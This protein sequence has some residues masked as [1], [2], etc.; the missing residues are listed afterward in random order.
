MNDALYILKGLGRVGVMCISNSR[1]HFLDLDTRVVS[2]LRFNFIEFP[3]Y[4]DNEILAILKHRAEECNALVP[5]SYNTKVLEMITEI[6]S[7]DARA[8]I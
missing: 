8:A 3:L 7:G 2:R 4:S 6:S 5:E 1:R